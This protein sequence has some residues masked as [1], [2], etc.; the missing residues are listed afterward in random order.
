MVRDSGHI[1]AFFRLI[2]LPN[3]LIVAAT[4]ILIRYSIISPLLAQGN[5]SLQL[6][7]GLFA[8][9]VL[10]TV[11]TTAAGYVINDYF[12]RKIDRVNKPSA[13][14]VGK[15]VYPRHAMAYHSAYQVLYLVSGYLLRPMYCFSV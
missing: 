5:M 12:D 3:L 8:M 15:L 13:V 6:P 7:N 10:A 4:Q 9:L 2:R 14:I 1:T 11:F